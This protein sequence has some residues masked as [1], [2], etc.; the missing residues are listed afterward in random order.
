MAR[1]RESSL[2]LGSGLWHIEWHILALLCSHKRMGVLEKSRNHFRPTRLL[3]QHCSECQ[4]PESR[5]ALPPS[6]PEMLPAQPS[7]PGGTKSILH[8]TRRRRCPLHDG[9]SGG[10]VG[11]RPN[12]RHEKRGPSV[13]FHDVL[14]RLRNIVTAGDA[15]SC[16]EVK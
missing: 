15:Y 5:H 8:V 12:P 9:I 4:A 1:G 11:R 2:L 6:S 10:L 16:R 7:P 14:R 3:D 13:S